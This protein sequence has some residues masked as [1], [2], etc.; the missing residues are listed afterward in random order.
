MGFSS[1]GIVVWITGPPQSGK[2]TFAGALAQALKAHRATCVLDGDD[3]R[4]A[5]VP[6]PAYDPESREAFYATLANLAA[7]VAR[8]GLVVVVA[9][10][11]HERTFRA[12]AKEIAGGRYLEVQI[13][14]TADECRARDRKGLYAAAETGSMPNLPGRFGPL[15]YE[16]S[17]AADVFAS[18]GF[19]EAAVHG[20]VG[21]ILRF[22][23]R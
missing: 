2:S 14:A 4:H 9:A 5:L 13:A 7:L 17:E 12:R 10:T 21:R 20:A 6:E 19:D 22:D 15:A 8:Q 23:E 11:A 1:G 3:V 16:P 18:G